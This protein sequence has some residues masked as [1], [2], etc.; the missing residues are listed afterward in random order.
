MK[1]WERLE[2]YLATLS[3]GSDF[4]ACDYAEAAGLEHVEA[5]ADI[6][7]YLAAQRAEDSNTNYVLRRQAGTRTR[8]ARWVIG[9][10]TADARKIGR[11]LFDDTACK[12]QRAMV[13]DLQR[14]A[15]LNPRAARV[16]D[17][18]TRAVLQGAL[19]VLESAAQGFGPDPDE[20]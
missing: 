7:A 14:L 16:V 10:K 1:R 19:V 11:A 9:V 2:Q 17:G 13:P 8:N 20:D 5:S 3:V 6:Q 12:V 18:Q 4:A 15:A